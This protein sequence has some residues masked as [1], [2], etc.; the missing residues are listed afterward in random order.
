[1]SFA[2][3]TEAQWE[4]ACR[5]G[6]AAPLSYGPVGADFSRHANLA[7][8]AL[9]IHPPKTGG[10]ESNITAHRGEGVFLSALAGGDI[11]CDDRYDDGAV[12]TAE[13]GGYEPNA[14]GLHDMHGNAAEWTLSS[15][16]PYPYQDADGRNALNPGGRRVVRGG[17][18]HDRPTR[19]R[20][21]FRLSYPAWQRVHNVGFRVVCDG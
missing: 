17:S 12:A 2:L 18:F 10:L 21:A 7:D 9:S 15:Y 19:C 8:N 13:V 14:W 1:M 4:Y 11:P 20:S 3:P 16:T 5:A 6:S